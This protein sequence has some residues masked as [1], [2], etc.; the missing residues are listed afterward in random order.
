MFF[1]STLIFGDNINFGIFSAYR[2]HGDIFR[3]RSS[4]ETF[5]FELKVICLP[6]INVGDIIAC[7]SMMHLGIYENTSAKVANSISDTISQNKIVSFSKSGDKG[8]RR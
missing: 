7:C 5:R 4:S 2:R 6:T 8:R 1:N 3:P